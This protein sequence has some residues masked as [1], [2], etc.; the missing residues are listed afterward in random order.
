M[1][2]EI[3]LTYKFGAFRL[4]TSRN[5]LSRDG[6]P[7][8]LRRKAYEALLILVRGGGRVI[9]KERMLR[10][11]WPD[12]FV[13]EGSLSVIVSALRKALGEERDGPKYI[14]TIPR[15]GYRFVTEV[16]VERDET[17]AAPEGFERAGSLS[18]VG[19]AGEGRNPPLSGAQPPA[20][21]SFAPAAPKRRRWLT[22][23]LSPFSSPA[24]RFSLAALLCAALIASAAFIIRG[25]WRPTTESPIDS[26]AVIPLVNAGDDLDADYLADGITENIIDQ[27]SRYPDLKVIART[28]MFRY[29]GRGLDPIEVGRELRVAGVVTGKVSRHGDDVSVQI[30]FVDVAT[31]RQLWGEKFNRPLSNLVAVQ[32]DVSNRIG[33]S[34]HVEL[35]SPP[36]QPSDAYT[37]D[38]EAYELYLRGRYFWNQ[39]TEEGVRK[40]LDYFTRAAQKDARYAAAYAGVADC[41]HVLPWVSEV[42]PEDAPAKAK[43]AAAKAIELDPSLSEAHVSLAFALASYD[44]DWAGAER[45]YRRAIELNPNYATAHQWYAVLL[46]I[47]GR[48]GEALAEI[49]RALQLDPLSIAVNSNAGT[50]YFFSRDYDAALAQFRR[51]V[52][53]APRDGDLHMW[54]SQVYAAKGEYGASVAEDKEG[55]SLTRGGEPRTVN[56]SAGKSQSEFRAYWLGLANSSLRLARTSAVRPSSIATLYALSGEKEKA[57][58]WLER[59]YEERD[60][61]LINLGVNPCYDSLRSDARFGELVRR[62][63]LR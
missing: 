32:T 40:G 30:E 9:E 29:K 31:G 25:H 5:L 50:I 12:T 8:P 14:E 15:V 4:D 7:V 19:Q 41:Y 2:E 44:W 62:M 60:S 13:E 55:V 42:S 33:E 49:D 18:E 54:L 22:A 17:F 51:T 1:S 23:A 16:L 24:G 39:R 6:E 59:A 47:Q 10:E 35:G 28:T 11:L 43:E 57:F 36:K 3:K 34:L 48:R 63:N 27:L 21:D 61:L 46:A 20:P 26:V 45:E 38:S 58:A 37:A 52:E 56:V 53:L